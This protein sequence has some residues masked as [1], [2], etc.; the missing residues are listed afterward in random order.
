MITIHS[1]HFRIWV[2][3][4]FLPEFLL[5]TCWSRPLFKL[6]QRARVDV[7]LRNRRNIWLRN[8]ILSQY[9]NSLAQRVKLFS[10]PP[11]LLCCA[12][13]ASTTGVYLYEH[14]DP[15]WKQQ[16]GPVNW[17]CCRKWNSFQAEVPW[18]AGNCRMFSSDTEGVGWWHVDC[19]SCFGLT[20]A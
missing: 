5:G 9:H 19:S 12:F 17:R 2:E 8:L 1:V 13:T 14:H 16:K 7:S 18:L 11:N 3:L 10:P 20:S 4:G 15:P 6:I